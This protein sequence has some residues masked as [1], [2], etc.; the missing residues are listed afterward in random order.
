MGL[1]EKAALKTGQSS[2]NRVICKGRFTKG[3]SLEFARMNTFEAFVKI[4]KEYGWINEKMLA[5]RE[6]YYCRTQ[7][8]D[9]DGSIVLGYRAVLNEKQSK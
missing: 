6:F 5:V 7:E 8:F 4:L 9:K 3:Q 1:E 2:I